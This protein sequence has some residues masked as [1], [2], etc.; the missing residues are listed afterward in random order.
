MRQT[1]HCRITVQIFQ[2]QHSAFPWG[3]SLSWHFSQRI[4]IN[5]FTFSLTCDL[6]QFHHS[7]YAIKTPISELLC[8]M[9]VIRGVWYLPYLSYNIK[10]MQWYWVISKVQM[11]GLVDLLLKNRYFCTAQTK[12]QTYCTDNTYQHVCEIC[13]LNAKKYNISLS[14]I[15]EVQ[16]FLSNVY[17]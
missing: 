12:P 3:I 17:L 7:V 13:E 11:L 2:K 10:N 6:L 8:Q 5:G 14:L 15:V 9:I 4:Q 16:Y 1:T